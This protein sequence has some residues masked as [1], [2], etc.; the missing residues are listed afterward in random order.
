[1]TLLGKMKMMMMRKKRIKEEHQNKRMMT[2]VN[3]IH[4]MTIAFDSVVHP[5]LVERHHASLLPLP[6]LHLQ[7]PIVSSFEGRLQ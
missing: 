2:I 4:K 3:L 7:L 1:M 5:T 6:L